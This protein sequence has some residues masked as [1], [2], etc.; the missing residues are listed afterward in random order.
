MRWWAS[1]GKS[2]RVRISPK[3]HSQIIS[4]LFMP[5]QPMFSVPF[6]NSRVNVHGARLPMAAQRSSAM[7]ASIKNKEASWK[8]S[9]LPANGRGPSVG[10]DRTTTSGHRSLCFSA[11]HFW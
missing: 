5:A 3:L 8:E 9:E 1:D 4:D 10:Q 6:G 2:R 11:K 7:Q